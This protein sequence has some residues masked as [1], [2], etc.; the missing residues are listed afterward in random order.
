MSFEDRMG[1]VQQRKAEEEI[2][3]YI[4]GSEHNAP[5]HQ[6]LGNMN[7]RLR[8]TKEENYEKAKTSNI[9][10]LWFFLIV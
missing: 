5:L 3:I 7:P 2:M 9:N 6:A 1:L 8:G 10:V 4:A